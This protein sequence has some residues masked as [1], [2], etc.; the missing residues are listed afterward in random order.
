MFVTADD[1]DC[2]PI[3]KVFPTLSVKIV[4]AQDL[5]LNVKK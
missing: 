4:N 5:T 1:S 2:L 3:C